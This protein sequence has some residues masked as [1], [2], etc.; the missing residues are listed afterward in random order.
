MASTPPSEF[1]P[2]A[3]SPFSLADD[4]AYE[5]WRATK[6]DVDPQ[7]RIIEIDD[8][9][10]ISDA[11]YAKLLT[12]CGTRNF[13]VFRV[14]RCPDDPENA[15]QAFGR[16]LGLIDLDQ[17][18]CAEDS[19]L[20][21]ITVKPTATDHVYIP[22]TN[23]PLGW[24]TDGYYNAGTHQIRGWL[25]YC[26]HPAAEGGANELLDHEIAY[27]RVRDEN[28]EWVRAL[29][30]ADAFTIPSNTEAGEEIRPDHSGPVFSVVPSDGTLHMRYSAR[31]RN[32]IWKDDTPTRDAA[33]FLLQL[34]K[35]GDD[36][37]VGHRLSAG[38]GVISNNVLH[39]RDGFRDDPALGSKRLIY[40]ARYYQRLPESEE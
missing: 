6:L 3:G 16:R 25:L 24:H 33:A 5:R 35:Q 40:R 19:G 2:A 34:F 4:R 9:S 8:L 28:P 7:P 29:M 23:R 11:E 21:A 38:E 39:R 14:T 1:N 36:M 20:T 26:V 10:R 22:Y 18:L 15:L 31:Q 12:D 17:N 37:L 30:A 13:A 32:V 27:I